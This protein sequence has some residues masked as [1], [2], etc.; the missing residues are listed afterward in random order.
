MRSRIV[1]WID[2]L[3]HTRVRRMG[4]QARIARTTRLARGFGVSFLVAPEERCYVEI[5]EEG[6]FNGRITFEARTGKVSIGDRCY[7]GAITIICRSGVTI[8][9]DVAIAWGTMLYDHDSHSPDWRQRL[10]SLRHFHDYYDRADCYET[11]DWTHVRTAPIVIGDRAWIGSDALI[12]KGVTIGEG[13]I[14]GARSVVTR[15]VAPYTIVAGNP[16]RV[17]RELPEEMR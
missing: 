2:W 3:Q 8:G 13:A 12:L 16:A 17:V 9:D 5:G 4:V 10:P 6:S 1:R 11:I 7:V 14:V 15:D